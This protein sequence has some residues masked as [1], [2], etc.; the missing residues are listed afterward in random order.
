MHNLVS[1]SLNLS[2]IVSLAD[3]MHM[4]LIKIPSNPN[5]PQNPSF[6]PPHL[7][8]ISIVKPPLYAD[9]RPNQ[10]Q[11]RRRN[12]AS[13]SS[14][15]VLSSE[16][17]PVVLSSNWSFISSSRSSSTIFMDQDSTHIARES[18]ELVFQMSNIVDSGL[19]RHTLS[20]LIALCDLGLNP[21]ALAAV[22]KEFRSDP[23]FTSSTPSTN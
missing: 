7:R 8:K 13:P 14:V 16:S 15:T 12:L 23:P 10:A 1:I 3:G 18:L 19:D 5:L 2:F 20:V 11:S 21:E 22:V 4:L 9:V 17:P 6:L